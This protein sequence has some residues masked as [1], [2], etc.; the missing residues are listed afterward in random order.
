FIGVMLLVLGGAG[1]FYLTYL[2]PPRGGRWQSGASLGYIWPSRVALAC[3]A[4]GALLTLPASAVLILR[5]LRPNKSHP[6][7]TCKQCG[8]DLA[9]NL[10]GKCPECGE[11]T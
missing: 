11:P 4:F 1:L 7:G 9:G 6:S 10:S 3:A 8:Y 5:R 2:A